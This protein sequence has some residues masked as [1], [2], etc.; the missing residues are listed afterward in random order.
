MVC[1]LGFALY[2]SGDFNPVNWAKESQKY[3]AWVAFACVLAYGV[4]SAQP[5]K[6]K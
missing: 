5:P 3:F 1:Y 4:F 6:Y 2:N